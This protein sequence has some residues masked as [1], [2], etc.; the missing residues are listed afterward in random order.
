[1]FTMLSITNKHTRPTT[2]TTT[3]TTNSNKLDKDAA[4]RRSLTQCSAVR[5]GEIGKVNC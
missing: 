4:K 3:T 1:M 5:K 2:T